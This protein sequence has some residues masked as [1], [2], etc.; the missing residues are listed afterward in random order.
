MRSKPR[1]AQSPRLRSLLSV[2]EHAEFHLV[3]GNAG[4][5]VAGV[6]AQIGAG[7]GCWIVSARLDG[8]AAALRLICAALNNGRIIVE[9]SI[10]IE[11]LPDC[12]G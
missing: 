8:S 11:Q 6:N 9:S 12:S 1:E 10:I 2:I 4:Q 7:I 3:R 5:P